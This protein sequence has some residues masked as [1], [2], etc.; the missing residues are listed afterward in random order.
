MKSKKRP[1]RSKTAVTLEDKETTVRLWLSQDMARKGWRR[2]A[3][4]GLSF[5]DY[6][7]KLLAEDADR[8]EEEKA[9]VLKF[10][11]RGHEK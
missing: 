1:K 9:K 4:L 3:D 7:L 5:N 11:R 2:A 8:L 6:C 10:P